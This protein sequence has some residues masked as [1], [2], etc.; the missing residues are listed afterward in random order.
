MNLTGIIHEI[1]MKTKE[2]QEKS[3]YTFMYARE[4]K[5]N[6]KMANTFLTTLP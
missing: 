4:A 6:M 1:N 2:E 3:K 5:Q